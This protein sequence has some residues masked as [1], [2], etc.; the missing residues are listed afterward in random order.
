[1]AETPTE[2]GNPA[3]GADRA[4]RADP[5][6][7]R[8]RTKTVRDMVLS[9]AVI[10]A[11]AYGLFL[12]VP[13]DASEDPVRVVEYRVEALSA[14]RAAPY[15]LLVPDDLTADWRATSVRYQHDSDHGALWRL[16]FMDPDNQYAA[17]GQA[18]GPADAFIADFTHGAEA[19]DETVR[20]DGEVWTRYTGDKYDALVRQTATVT[21]IVTGTAP[22]SHLQHLATTLAPPPTS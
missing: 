3:G 20:V 21:T 11:G 12:F 4:D 14:A 18:D 19:T 1:M 22:D 2:P 16:G 15:E 5:E 8:P 17:L 10:L 13:H 6:R 7:R 9:M